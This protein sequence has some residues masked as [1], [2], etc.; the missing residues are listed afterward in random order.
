MYPFILAFH[1]YLLSAPSVPA[2]SPQEF[3]LPGRWGIQIVLGREKSEVLMAPMSWGR[4][5]GSLRTPIRL[6]KLPEKGQ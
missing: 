4:F 1:K 5:G 6:A 3:L 2:F